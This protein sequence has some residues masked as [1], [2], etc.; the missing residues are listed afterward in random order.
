ML[1]AK[2]RTVN[3]KLKEILIFQ[4]GHQFPPPYRFIVFFVFLVFQ[5]SD[6]TD[7]VHGTLIPGLIGDI[8]HQAFQSPTAR[9]VLCHDKDDIS[10]EVGSCD[11]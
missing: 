8:I 6:C 5:K 2:Q 1:K 4:V 10:W 9:Q 7:S 3:W 11:W